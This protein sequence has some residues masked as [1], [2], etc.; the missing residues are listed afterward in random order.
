MNRI[1]SA[2]PPDNDDYDDDDIDT[3]CCVHYC[4]NNYCDWG[5]TDI[6]ALRPYRDQERPHHR[7]TAFPQ[8]MGWYREWSDIGYY[9]QQS[10]DEYD[11]FDDKQFHCH[12]GRDENADRPVLDDDDMVVVVVVVVVVVEAAGHFSCS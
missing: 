6:Q 4:Y 7:N 12:C 9:C 11:H 8:R 3:S 5:Y 2:H 1:L 10:C